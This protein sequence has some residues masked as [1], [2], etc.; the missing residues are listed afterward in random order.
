MRCYA[1]ALLRLRLELTARGNFHWDGN[2]FS[3][4]A[5]NVWLSI[6]GDNQPILRATLRD[7]EGN[8]QDRD[9]NLGERLGNNNGE[10]A[11]SQTH[12]FFKHFNADTP[13]D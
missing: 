5:D 3:G 2:G 7:G 8:G 6:E 1:R 4:G 9:I 10:F 12:P 13:Q 11:Y